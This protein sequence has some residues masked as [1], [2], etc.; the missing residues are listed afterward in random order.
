MSNNLNQPKNNC[1]SS[2]TV[3]GRSRARMCLR[4]GH[5]RGGAEHYVPN[6]FGASG[7]PVQPL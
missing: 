6:H 3:R 5:S 2:E 4:Y 7:L 1:A